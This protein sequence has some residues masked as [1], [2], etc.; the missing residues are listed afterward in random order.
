MDGFGPLLGQNYKKNSDFVAFELCS[1]F[2]PAMVRFFVS[3]N[4]GGGTVYA[5]LEVIII[6]FFDFFLCF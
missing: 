4:T 2:F 1:V 3:R 6:T 5:P